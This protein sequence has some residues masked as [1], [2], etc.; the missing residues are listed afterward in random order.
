M[1]FIFIFVIII[2]T[3][4]VIWAQAEYVPS[5]NRVYP[6]LERMET[7]RIIPDYNSF[8]IPKTR[9]EIAEYIGKVLQ[10]VNKLDEADKEFL[11]DLKIEFEYE[12]F[13][14]LEKSEGILNGKDY[15][16]FSQ[17]QK[18]LYLFNDP[19]NFN[20]FINL[21]A[22]GDFLSKN[23]F[24]PVSN[25]S[26]FLGIIGGEI[27]STISDKFGLFIKGTDGN[28]SGSREA[29]YLKS[30]LRYNYKF[31]E[32][33]SETF[34]DETQ[35]YLTADFKLIR[36]KYGRDRMNV[37]YGSEKII[38]G[39]NAPLFDYLGM[40]IKYKFFSYTFFHAQLLGRNY[41]AQ[42]TTTGGVNVVDS[43]YTVYHR[44]GFD[45]S[46]D[47]NFGAGELIVYGER[48]IDLS[49]LNPFSFYKSVEHSN[50]DRD[51]AMLFLDFNN[52]S[53]EGL[54]FYA[55]LLIDDISFDKLGTGWWGNQTILDAGVYSE[56]LYKTLP[57]GIRIQYTKIDPYVY[58]HRLI[59]NNFTDFGYNL[60]SFTDPNT[61]LFLTEINYRFNSRLGLS[62][63][64]DFRIH[65]AN[66][67][68][69]DG[70]VK[71]N[72]GGDISLGHRTFDREQVDFLDGY[73]EY[74]RSYTLRVLYEPVNEYYLT[75][76]LNYLNESLQTVRNEQ[77]NAMLT[78]S[79]KI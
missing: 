53:I 52:K 24:S 48:P 63:I 15:N 13:G 20:I 35:G 66:P 49:Y 41:Y 7:L 57:L 17:E 77:Q 4:S 50:R 6:F 43:K 40:N 31:N 28:V 18:Y 62:F 76:D 69:E 65:G 36:F 5:E 60:S 58:T 64:F 25:S 74:S 27:R 46:K 55:T 56:L 42:D 79:I 23:K 2:I 54:K 30:D 26:A 78:L 16:P 68:S 67:I 29:A 51:N 12:L 21:T 32:K 10:S 59:R 37:G 11:D 75:L 71:E 33:L 34:F 39:N 14:T 72:V 47:I 61:E 73:R 70:S 44:I 19:G 8:E 1:R 45:L 22:E 9:R 38:L 3:F